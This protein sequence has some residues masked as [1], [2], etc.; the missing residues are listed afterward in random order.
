[1]TNKQ[2]EIDNLLSMFHDFEIVYAEF[3]ANTLVL[4]I[5]IP[6]GSMWKEDD[7]SYTIRLELIDCNYFSCDYY[8]I[9][10]REI[11]QLGESLN[12]DETEKITTTNPLD[13]KDLG[14][15]I[16]N[17]TNLGNGIYELHCLSHKGFEY[18]SITISLNDYKIFD[19]D[20]NEISL[21]VMNQWCKDWWDGIQKMWDEQKKNGYL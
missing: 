3:K 8:K 21:E 5:T 20:G 13:L 4:R 16:Q 14:L 10:N 19:Q 18:A 7:Y 17:R 12:K 15:S 1:M 9:K 6:W 11:F 2:N